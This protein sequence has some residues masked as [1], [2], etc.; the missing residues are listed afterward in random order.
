MTIV[1]AIDGSPAAPRV[2]GRAIEQARR[3]G[4]PLDVVHVFHPPSTI[5]GVEGAYLVDATRI[6]EAEREE[7]WEAVCPL[8]DTSGIEWNRVDL[9]GY[10]PRAIVERARESDADLI[11]IGTRGRGG[12]AS[13]V[14]GSTSLA[15]IHEAPCDV[16]VVDTKSISG[17]EAP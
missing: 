17:D 8:L 15:V 7:V 1:A 13:L 5:Y 9:E 2:V 10:P 3:F 4:E 14:L 6:A 12:F 11:V 16:L